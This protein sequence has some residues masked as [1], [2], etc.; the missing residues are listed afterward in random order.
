VSIQ[1]NRIG[2]LAMHEIHIGMGVLAD[3]NLPGVGDESI[4]RPERVISV[5]GA[6]VVREERN[7]RRLPGFGQLAA[8][9][10]PPQAVVVPVSEPV[11]HARAA[12]QPKIVLFLEPGVRCRLGE[13]TDIGLNQAGPVV[14]GIR[15]CVGSEKGRNDEIGVIRAV[16]RRRQSELL[17]IADALLRT[18]IPPRL[19]QRRQQH[20]RQNRDDRN[21][22][23]EL[24]EG[25]K[26]VHKPSFPCISGIPFPHD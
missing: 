25:K 9:A 11:R 18:R 5:C 23:E 17:Q 8:G 6:D 12:G 26:L 19:C 21:Y 2:E 4:P 7:A 24:D 15:A 14:P 20:R 10:P 1:K 22:D 3:R 16:H 13:S